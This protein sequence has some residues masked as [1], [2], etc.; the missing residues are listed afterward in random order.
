MCILMYFPAGVQPNPEHL[1]NACENNPHGFGWALIVNGRILTGHS[2]DADHARE[3]FSALRDM[4][5]DGDALFHARITTHGST[6]IGN[7]HPF[8]VNGRRD[9]VVAHN[10]I[11]P[12]QPS[13]G[14]RRSDT[15]IFA[16]EVLMRDFR[17]LDRAKT[18]SRLSAW[19]GY[20]KVLIL[21]VNPAYRQSVYLINER[22]GDW[23]YGAWYSNDSYKAD[24]WSAYTWSDMEW[25]STIGRASL[26]EDTLW[27]CQNPLCGR[28]E[29]YCECYAPTF[30]VARYPDLYEPVEA[31]YRETDD[32]DTWFCR[33]CRLVGWINPKSLKCEMC[34]GMYCCD[35]PSG[36]CACW[37]P[38]EAKAAEERL[39]FVEETAVFLSSRAEMVPVIDGEEAL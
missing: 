2:M 11:M 31:G 9:M 27:V 10:G 8:W 4:H 14:D 36:S 3:Q 33:L 28:T 29:D 25:P 24:P 22:M 20:S 17:R 15:R 35:L 37:S 5:P 1:K 34:K 26:D 30:G 16:E 13:K 23:L 32:P 19:V 18:I 7:C 6:D 21:S 38:D 39:R 12:C